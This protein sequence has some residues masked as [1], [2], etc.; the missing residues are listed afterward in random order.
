MA[1]GQVV[2]GFISTVINSFPNKRLMGYSYFEQWKDLMPSFLLSILMAVIVWLMNAI[3]VAPL[4]LLVMQIV[5]G[6]ILYASF[7][8]IFKL[9]VYTYFIDTLKGFIKR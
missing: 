2:C 1:T 8:R 3:T 5:V 7:S 4:L 6:I 9:E